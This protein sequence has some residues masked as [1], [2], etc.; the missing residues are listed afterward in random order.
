[1]CIF[2]QYQSLIIF[3][4]LHLQVFP[5][6]GENIIEVFFFFFFKLSVVSKPLVFMILFIVQYSYVTDRSLRLKETIQLKQLLL[7]I[8]LQSQDSNSGSLRL[9]FSTINHQPLL[10]LSGQSLVVQCLRLGFA[11]QGMWE[12][13]SHLHPG[14]KD[15]SI[16][17]KQYG[18]KL[19]KDFWKQ[20]SAS[21]VFSALWR[22]SFSPPSAALCWKQCVCFGCLL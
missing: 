13:R 9:Q 8:S 3:S 16:R 10:K 22:Y 6:V 21:L 7:A 20:L 4:Q 11:V 15:Q 14:Q 18:N 2:S 1:M 19:S 17:Q 12:L 5:P